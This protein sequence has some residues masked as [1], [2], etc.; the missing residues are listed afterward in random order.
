MK[1]FPLSKLF[2]FLFA[3]SLVVLAI[4]FFPR[5]LGKEEGGEA[6]EK[7]LKDLPS[8]LSSPQS[9]GMEGGDE[10]RSK[11][12]P[13][14]R[15][16][17]PV[18]MSLVGKVE[19]GGEFPLSLG[20]VL[21]LPA[22]PDFS[23]GLGSMIQKLSMGKG[24]QLLAPGK[25]KKLALAKAP[26]GKDG[27]FRF[28]SPPLGRFS[29]VLDHPFYYF[30][31][32][33]TVTTIKDRQVVVGPYQATLGALVEVR[34]SDAQGLPIKGV[35]IRM[36]SRP[37]FSKM[38]DPAKAGDPSLWV[39]AFL[40]N[41]GK[42]DGKGIAIFSGLKAGKYLVHGSKAGYSSQAREVVVRG[43]TRR[44]L[45][46]IFTKGLLLKVLVKDPQG[47][48]VPGVSV[49]V[50]SSKGAAYWGM[51][52]GGARMKRESIS[53]QTDSKGIAR[54]DTLLPGSLTLRIRTP[55]FVRVREEVPH[56][57][58]GKG[59]LEIALARGLAYRGTVLDSRSQALKGVL[60]APLREAGQEV[61]GFSG[62][63]FLPRNVFEKMAK[64]EGVETDDQG[65]FVLWGFTKGQKTKLIA[66]KEGYAVQIT[67]EFKAG[68]QGIR[69]QCP[70][71][72]D[73]LGRVVDQ[74]T[75][76]PVSPF[77]IRVERN[78]FMMFK[79]LLKEVTVKDPAGRFRLRGLPPSGV[80]ISIQAKDKNTLLLSKTLR[81]GEND[82]GILKMQPPLVV[83][84]RIVDPLGRG[85]PGVEVWVSRG[86]MADNPEMHMIIGLR[87]SRTKAGGSF[88]LVGVPE[89]RFRLAAFRKGFSLK[90]SK[91]LR[92]PSKT[93]VLKNVLLEMSQGGNVKGVIT[94]SE[95]LPLGGA[96]V[97]AKA[98]DQSYSQSV[99]SDADGRFEFLGL[100][101]GSY[102]LVGM[103]KGFFEEVGREAMGAAGKDS[104][105][106]MKRVSS[107]MKKMARTQVRVHEGETSEV[108]LE[109]PASTGGRVQPD[110]R[111]TV[112]LGGN[113]LAKGMVSLTPIGAGA[114]PLIGTVEKGNFRIENVP[115]GSYRIRF[116]TG[117]GSGPVGAEKELLLQGAR[118]PL[119]FSFPGSLLEGKVLKPDG[120]PA[121]S[122]LIVRF[123]KQ[124][125]R[126][127]AVDDPNP[128]FNGN[129]TLTS[130]K[131]HFRFQG[132][133]AGTYDLE[134]RSSGFL[135]K[136]A[137]SGDLKGILLDEGGRRSGLVIHLKKGGGIS[138]QVLADGKPMKRAVVRLVDAMGKPRDLLQVQ[139][140]D[141]EG[142]ASFENVAGGEWRV[143]ARGR[144][145]APK[146]SAVQVVE[147]GVSTPVRLE[148]SKGTE[149]DLS[150]S[151]EVPLAGMA[152]FSVWRGDGSFVLQGAI[153]SHV[154]KVRVGNLMP[155]KYR[156]RVENSLLGRREQEVVVPAKG[157][158]N[159]ELK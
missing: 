143:L 140:T 87:K 59:F 139:V 97:Q 124:G 112:S 103:K 105:N 118:N 79:N 148:L 13:Q 93:R 18:R 66:V 33:P 44:I 136:G 129:A 156:L 30:K 3:A 5:F 88:R 117:F 14:E 122:G 81:E 104:Q 120:T 90:R 29:L 2:L 99:T 69:I 62:S 102:A 98:T 92:V 21:L 22:P 150:V 134:V 35:K 158:A 38:M 123:W 137:G 68:T 125:E 41:K 121:G 77:I 11:L 157:T 8:S 37:D 108:Q 138:V 116:Q 149:V 1:R 52:F 39:K 95:G 49:R 70:R 159:W 147:K 67:P 57:R 94:S 85:L 65:R 82:L 53:K 34:A 141:A 128:W 75:G 36:Q 119:H 74:K 106:I 86:R 19:G 101:E 96:L 45:R 64:R 40:P 114:L 31:E 115:D 20:T 152:I 56:F 17:V 4:F 54:F 25:N 28:V 154:K 61:M 80:Q 78:A 43:G 76:A 91:V 58:G 84:G 132:I 130:S 48:P 113:P 60:V 144:D 110:L 107:F 10:A 133:P 151:E 127:E 6:L 63:S 126:S 27:R 83:E 135:R 12:G 155:G 7:A 89:G 142:R 131:G 153:P 46:F 42:T 16:G 15:T 9:K 111:G 72:A 71:Q 145:W 146:L 23:G 109:I 55:G 50:E 32:V 24:A 100:A 47:K 51:S 26:L 73:L